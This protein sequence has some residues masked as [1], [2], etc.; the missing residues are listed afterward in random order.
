MRT[1]LAYAKWKAIR[2]GKATETGWAGGT[3]GAVARDAHGHV[4]A[5]TSTGGM[6]NK[7]AG[8]VGDSP[9]PGAGTYAD[10]EAGAA[11][12]TGHGEAFIRTAFAARIVEHLDG[13]LEEATKSALERMAEKTHGTGGAIVVDR[14]GRAAW[15]R[16]TET[17]SFGIARADDAGESQESGT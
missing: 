12:T 3:V 6:I 4:A 1:E 17:M 2:D 14:R 9:I 15:A 10:D 13:A 7:S 11:S 5:A 16:N 8:R